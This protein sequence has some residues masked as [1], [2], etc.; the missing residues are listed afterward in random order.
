MKYR[1]GSARSTISRFSQ[2]FLLRK[3]GT[4]A[5]MMGLILCSIGDRPAFAANRRK[6]WAV[7]H[8]ICV[9]AYQGLGVP[10]PCLE[11][12]IALVSIMALPCSKSL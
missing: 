1:T 4:F 11:V 3:A 2:A 10:F 5:A 8:A 6:L 9:P 12:N 7:V